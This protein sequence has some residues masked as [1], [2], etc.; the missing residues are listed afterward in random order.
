MYFTQYIDLKLFAADTFE[1]LLEDEVQNNLPLGFIKNV[2]R[3]DTSGWLLFTVKDDSGAVLLTAAC[4]PPHNI[5]LYETRN[6]PND[7]ALKLLADQLRGMG[8]TFPGTLSE[9]GTAGRFAEMF[10]GK[11]NFY[12]HMSMNIM[13]LDAVCDVPGAPGFRRELRESDLFFLP[14]WAKSFAEDCRVSVSDIETNAEKIRAEIGKNTYYIWENEHP[15]SV[16][17][18]R[19]NTE[20]GAGIN[21]VY[22]PPFYRGKGYASSV[23]AELARD[24]LAR[25]HKF[26][27]LFADAENPVSCGIYRKIG[28][29]DLCVFDDIKFGG[30]TKNGH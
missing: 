22:T 6:K 23:V 25:G 4:T 11:G 13:R 7:A 15:V 19:R 30:Q 16:A 27:F 20:N 5:V 1:I 8:Y 28:F 2:Q 18:N 12:H 21:E 26:C 3:H 9:R 24:L 14:Y 10:A 17:V 29:H